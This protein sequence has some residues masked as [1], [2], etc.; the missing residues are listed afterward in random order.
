MSLHVDVLLQKQQTGM[1]QKDVYFTAIYR[2]DQDVIETLCVAD[3]VLE[4]IKK[5]YPS[6]E[7]LY[8]KSDNAGCYAGNSCAELE[9]E[10]CK[11]HNITFY[12]HDCNEPQKGKDQADR[13]SS[14]AKR[15]MTKYVNGGKD[16]ISADDLKKAVLFRGSPENAKVSVVEIN[17]QDCEIE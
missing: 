5:D 4:Q 15:Y 2:S 3:H 9:F 1:L 10:I 17:K 7:G 11:K 6:L 16:I 14:I 13:E 12:R 8:H